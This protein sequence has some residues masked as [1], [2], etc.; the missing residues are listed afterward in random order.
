MT[1]HSE[2]G[3]VVLSLWRGR[4]CSGSFRLEAEELPRFLEALQAAHRAAGESAEPAESAS[5]VV[6][7]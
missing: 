5:T 2:V 3:V 7:G 6:A 4:V 1:W